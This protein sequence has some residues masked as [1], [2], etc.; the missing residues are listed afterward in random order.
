M[1]EG[2]P[3]ERGT[4][5]RAIQSRHDLPRREAANEQ[6]SNTAIMR[7]HEVGRAQLVARP[8]PDGFLADPRVVI[9]ELAGFGERGR[10]FLEAPRQHHDLEDL[11]Q[12]L[13]GEDHATKCGPGL[14]R[15]PMK[16]Y[17]DL[18]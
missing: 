11:E 1:K 5:A 16:F 6:R 4:I 7:Q 2:R 14:E 15:G 10:G 9:V 8:D 12:L 3:S 13:A 17:R 18:S